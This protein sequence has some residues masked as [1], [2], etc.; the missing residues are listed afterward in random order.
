MPTS[1]TKSKP[2]FVYILLCND[3]TLYTGITTDLKARL[4]KHKSGEGAKYTRSHGAN[5]IV[6]SEKQKTR[7]KATVREME[8]KKLPRKEKV[9]LLK[10]K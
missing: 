10:L 9:K 1:K 2:W 3:G 7:S 4:A 8:I 5:K 6:F